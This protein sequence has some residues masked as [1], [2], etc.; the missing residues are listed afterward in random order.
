M[1]KRHMPVVVER[2][3]DRN[4]SSRMSQIN[5]A[6]SRHS[7]LPERSSFLTKGLSGALPEG[8]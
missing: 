1:Y 2:A 7:A 4:A 3:L 5:G 6:P 8:L